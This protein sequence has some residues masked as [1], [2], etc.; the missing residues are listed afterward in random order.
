MRKCTITLGSFLQRSHLPKWQNSRI[1]PR[2][3][4]KFQC[5]FFIIFKAAGKLF[6]SKICK[7]NKKISPEP[8]LYK[9]W[10]HSS[11]GNPIWSNV[12]ERN[13]F[14][15]RRGFFYSFHRPP[16]KLWEGNVLAGV[17]LSFCSGRS[18]MWP[19][20]M[21]HRTSLYSPPSTRPDM[22][23]HCTGHYPQA[24]DIPVLGP[25]PPPPPPPSPV[26]PTHPTAMRSCFLSYLFVMG[27]DPNVITIHDFI[28]QSQITW[29]TM[30]P[31]PSPYRNPAGRSPA[32]SPRYSNLFTW[33]SPHK[34]PFIIQGP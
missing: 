32:P 19:L 17:C 29:G 18:P 23:S 27:S 4:S 22:R 3:I 24:W 15:F 9:K 26:H 6:R 28:R 31:F 12:F 21:M 8:K 16:T 2:F 11:W 30:V 7:L 1:S 34:D 25:N 33:T 5:I 13:D 20:H 10:T 14:S